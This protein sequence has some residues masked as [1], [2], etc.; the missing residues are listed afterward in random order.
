MVKTFFSETINA[1]VFVEM[2]PNLVERSGLITFKTAIHHRFLR[3]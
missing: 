3:H 1:S 2:P